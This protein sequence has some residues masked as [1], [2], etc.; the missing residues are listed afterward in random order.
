M[1]RTPVSSEIT[2]RNILYFSLKTPKEARENI[3]E[4]IMAPKF[5][6]L[7]TINQQIQAV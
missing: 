6:N 7:K 3:L 2:S 4:E 1:K 5:S